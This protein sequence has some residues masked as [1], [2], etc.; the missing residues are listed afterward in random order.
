MP[1]AAEDIHKVVNLQEVNETTRS[2]HERTLVNEFGV[3]PNLDRIA[4]IA[5][6]VCQTCRHREQD[7]GYEPPS[8]PAW[9]VPH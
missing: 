7:G 1:S 6:E 2:Q 8:P 9:R 4:E 3:V 5:R